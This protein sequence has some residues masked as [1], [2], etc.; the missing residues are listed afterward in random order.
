MSSTSKKVTFFCSSTK[1]ISYLEFGGIGQ[2]HS[3]SSSFSTSNVVE[4]LKQNS[5][6]R[7]GE[8]RG[9]KEIHAFQIFFSGLSEV[10]EKA[11]YRI[12]TYF[13]PKSTM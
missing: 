6:W 9:D 8:V 2:G 13:L 11:P 3:K 5:W 10:V 12:S 1:G 4:G 7:E